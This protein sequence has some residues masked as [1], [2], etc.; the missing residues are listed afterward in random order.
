MIGENPRGGFLSGDWYFCRSR[1]GVGDAREDD[2]TGGVLGLDED[3]RELAG[4]VQAVSKEEKFYT[5]SQI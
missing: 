5:V 2:E 4:L 1:E 3:P